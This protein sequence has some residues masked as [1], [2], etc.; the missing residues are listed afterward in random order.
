MR[1]KSRA[2]WLGPALVPPI[3]PMIA[4]VAHAK[5]YLSTE[6]A[7]NVIAPGNKFERRTLELS[8]DE[9]ARIA[10]ASGERVRSKK[11]E[12]FKAANGDVVFID[13]VLGKHEFIKI[14]AGVNAK[15]NALRG[16]EILEY[17]E[18]Y[19]HEVRNPE[20]RKQFEGKT[21]DSKLK[22]DE[23]IRNI[24]GAT[25]SSAHVTGGARRLLQTYEV[26]KLRL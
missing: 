3:A 12:Y 4:I 14:A 21:I 5:T 15:T 25:L 24:S 22:L 17:R 19:G 26:V 7:A 10:K 2:I 20:W 18:S 13:E 11:L 1:I 23:D 8:D 16:V 6:E 9:A